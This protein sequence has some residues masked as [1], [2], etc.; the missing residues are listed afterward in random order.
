MKEIYV[1]LVVLCYNSAVDCVLD[2][3]VVVV[4]GSRTEKS[5]FNEISDDVERKL[6][7]VKSVADFERIF[8]INRYEDNVV[9]REINGFSNDDDA[10]VVT[11]VKKCRT[12]PQEVEI[13]NEKIKQFRYYPRCVT[14]DRCTG[15]CDSNILNKCK[16]DKTSTKYKSV[17]KIL[18]NGGVDVVSIP[19]TNHDTCKCG[20]KVEKEDCLATQRFDQN[21][22][23]C[24]CKIPGTPQCPIRKQWDEHKCE[25]TCSKP[26][27]CHSTF[28]WNPSTCQC[29]C[30]VTSC[31]TGFFLD[32]SN[33]VCRNI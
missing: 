3:G 20:C 5:D 1:L 13:P 17:Y 15:C 30:A 21:N 27:Q 25:C 16:P 2:K 28:K 6:R 12:E 11:D 9:E 10:Q 31:P 19:Y 18:A 33:C 32:P 26:L 7:N 23:E 14:A 8:N 29:E 22:C 24:K 4:A